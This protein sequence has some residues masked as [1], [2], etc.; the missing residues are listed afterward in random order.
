MKNTIKIHLKNKEDYINNYNNEILSYN[1]SNYILEETKGIST[2]QKI[3]FEIYSDFNM[4]EIEK[5]NF[6]EM[7]RKNFGADISEILNLST[8]IRIINSLIL[9]IGIIFIL[10]EST[11]KTE[12][13]SEFTLIIGWI[14]I[15]EA[16]CNILYKEVENRHNTARKK[17]IVN[18]KIIFN[19]N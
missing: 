3:K 9:F 19:N 18:A 16:I 7:I 4:N 11:L 14:F 5:N 13:L 10:I 6:V 8:K 1:L 15:G 12:I 17:Q 2:K